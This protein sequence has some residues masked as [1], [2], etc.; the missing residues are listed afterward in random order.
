MLSMTLSLNIQYILTFCVE[1][2]VKEVEHGCRIKM[3]SP[4]LMM[5]RRNGIHLDKS[6]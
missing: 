6:I 3:A 4:R 1:Q 5:L 2:T